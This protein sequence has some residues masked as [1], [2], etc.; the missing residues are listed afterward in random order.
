M[1]Q[2][3]IFKIQGEAP[4]L[5]MHNG[6]LVDPANQFSRKIKEFSSKR[7]KA[8]ADYE[9]MARAEFLGSLYLDGKEPCIPG[10][11]FEAALIGRGGSA[12]KEKMGKEAA[13]AL[14][15][16][17]NFPLEY[18]GPRDPFELWDDE[19]FRLVAPVRIG[20]SRVMRTR[21]LFSEWA[22]TVSL[23]FND[24]LLDEDVIRR[25]VEIAGEQVG[26]MDWRPK[27]GRFSVVG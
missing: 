19:R 15:V 16:V 4:G 26:L 10:Y 9:A 24:A 2:K 3:L 22:A 27:H 12:R 21:P 1:I 7:I 11:I 25:W 17:D 5:L 6:Q 8:D 13:A 18:D 20:Q 14:W 23:E